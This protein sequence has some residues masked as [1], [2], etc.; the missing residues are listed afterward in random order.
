MSGILP[1]IP[2]NALNTTHPEEKVIY[3][4]MLVCYMVDPNPKPSS[5]V[6]AEL[7]E[8]E[9]SRLSQGGK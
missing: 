4:P 6:I 3:D 7:L 1:R 8:Y 5:P 2:N 9:L